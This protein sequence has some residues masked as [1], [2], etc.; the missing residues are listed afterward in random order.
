[1]TMEARW[2]AIRRDDGPRIAVQLGTGERYSTTTNN[3]PTQTRD[4]LVRAAL[5]NAAIGLE[6][7]SL[8]MIEI[9]GR[10]AAAAEALGRRA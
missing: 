9:A 8:R 6:R 4:D 5:V 7:R 1:M 10:A 3:P 2:P